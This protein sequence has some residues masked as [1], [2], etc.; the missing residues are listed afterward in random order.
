MTTL[1]QRSATAQIIPLPGEKRGS[2]DR[3]RLSAGRTGNRGDAGLANTAGH[4]RRHL[5]HL[6]RHPRLGQHRQG[7]SDRDRAGQGGT[8]RPH[9]GG[10]GLRNRTVRRILV[11]DGTLVKAGQPLILMDGTLAG[12]DRERF[13]DATISAD[14]DIA[15]LTALVTAPRPASI[16]SPASRPSRRLSR[17]RVAATAPTSRPRRQTRRRRPGNCRATAGCRQL[18]GGDRPD[19]R[20]GAACP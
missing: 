6:R 3:T 11:D 9:Q 15:R 17:P 10:S 8:C 5:R 7:R 2:L 12:A 1:P 4:I 18:R 13:R 20:A 19:R 14:L 16:P